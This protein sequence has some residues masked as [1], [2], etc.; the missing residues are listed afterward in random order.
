MTAPHRTRTD[1]DSRWPAP[2]VQA[3]GCA[4]CVAAVVAVLGVPAA[5]QRPAVAGGSGQLLVSSSPLPDARHMV[6]VVDPGTRHAAVYLVDPDGTLTLKSVR[7]LSWDLMV[8]EFNAQE[9][10]P[11]AVRKLL[12]AGPAPR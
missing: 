12:E 7:D 2:A 11:A 9:P 4:M 5:G 3:I 1:R 6:L 8:G 10:K